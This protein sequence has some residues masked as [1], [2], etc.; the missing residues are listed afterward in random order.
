MM[1]AQQRVQRKPQQRR[2]R[3]AGE[4]YEIRRQ[5]TRS[6]AG[7][8]LRPE[9]RSICRIYPRC[10]PRRRCCVHTLNGAAPPHRPMYS[11]TRVTLWLIGQATIR[12][13]RSPPDDLELNAFVVADEISDTPLA[14]GFRPRAYKT[15]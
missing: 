1:L 12:N 13:Q 14:I 15:L 5:A 3:H 7:R 2:Q 10:L 8:P 6:N 4:T 9:S 11:K